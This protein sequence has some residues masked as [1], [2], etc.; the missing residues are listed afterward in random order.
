MGERPALDGL[1]EADQLKGHFLLGRATNLLPLLRD[2]DLLAVLL[3]KD[4]DHVFPAA[5]G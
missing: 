5:W 1:D 2:E 3:C 4:V